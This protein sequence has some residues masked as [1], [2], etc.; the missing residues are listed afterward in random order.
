[1][2]TNYLTEIL[3]PASLGFIMLGMGMTLVPDDFKR[4]V[5][6]PK[7]VAIGL[8]NQLILLPVVGFV[9]LLLLP[10]R[11]PELAVGLMILAACPGGATSNLIAHLSKGDTALSITLT[12]LSSMVVVLTIPLIVNFALGYFLEQGEYVPL[13]VLD[14]VIKVFI[15]TVVPVVVGMAIKARF[16]DFSNRMERPFKIASAA[17]LFIIIL[18]AILKER[19]NVAD[20][21]AQAGPAALLLNLSTLALG[22]FSARL[23]GLNRAQSITISIE[24]GLQNGTLGIA[25]AA[26][27][28]QNPAMTIPSAIYGL[29]MFVTAGAIIWWSNRQ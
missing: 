17:L 19:D 20:Y 15:I 13:P 3:L 27:L 11:T 8:V 22:L 14:T 1:M 7:A 25:I 16:N 9:L 6:Y 21:F 4:V 29:I 5:L 10:M 18:A 28:L 24:S 12:A 26:G 2:Q 23:L